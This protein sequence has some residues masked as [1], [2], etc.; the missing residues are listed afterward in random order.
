[1]KK[2]LIL[3][4][5]GGSLITDKNKAFTAKND[6]ILRLAKEIKSSLK[7]SKADL[8]IGHG[9][10]SFGHIVAA[11]YQTQKG[12]INKDSILGFPLVADAARKINVI[13]MDS[14]LK[15]GLK[16]VSFS[17]FSF[18][19]TKNEKEESSLIKPIKKALEIG[20]IPIIYGD[21]IMDQTK[22]FCIYSGEKILN[23]L[24][25]SLKDN[26]S[27][28]KIIY[29]GQTNGV[30]DE[31]GKTIDKITPKSYGSIKKVLKGSAGVDVTGG[32]IHK[33]EEAIELV[34]RLN[35][36]SL[37]INAKRKNFLKYAILG[38][39]VES[40]HIAR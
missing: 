30:Y 7:N 40:T 31:K 29:C 5:L 4:K 1:M 22:G 16:V 13:V 12:I 25:E 35:V 38:K 36:E 15:V 6:L 11:K 2:T 20:L 18:I 34:N 39:A 19:Y 24:A 32:M 28:I 26:Y 33:V 37:I 21:V 9:S 27:T 14:L 8:I 10:G 23:H 3:V 17:P